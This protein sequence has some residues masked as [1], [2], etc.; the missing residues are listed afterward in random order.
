MEIEVILAKSRAEFPTK[1]N[2]FCFLASTQK[3]LKKLRVG[4]QNWKHQWFTE[5]RNV[6]TTVGY[7]LLFF[8]WLVNLREKVWYTPTSSIWMD[9]KEWMAGYH[10]GDWLLVLLCLTAANMDIM[11]VLVAARRCFAS[12]IRPTW[13]CKHGYFALFGVNVAIRPITIENI[14]TDIN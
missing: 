4:K 12:S 14:H 11:L 6:Y 2:W 5:H 9:V 8:H 1:V 13:L 10:R 7:C 3:I